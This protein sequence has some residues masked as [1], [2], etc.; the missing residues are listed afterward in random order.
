MDD[1]SDNFLRDFDPDYNYYD[2]IIDQN[3]LFNSYNSV[4]DFLSNNPVSNNDKNFMT[5]F[6]QNIR[7][8]N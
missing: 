7:S 4:S 6:S 3:N 2:Q 5:I 1:A 8:M